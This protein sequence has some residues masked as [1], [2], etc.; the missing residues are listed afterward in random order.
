M[1]SVNTLRDRK[2]AY[3]SF[4]VQPALVKD[5]RSF[6]N[7]SAFFLWQTTSILLSKLYQLSEILFQS[8][9]ANN[10]DKLIMLTDA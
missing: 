4:R 6:R 3:S 10:T 2:L 9:N 7:V 5:G 1:K 8:I